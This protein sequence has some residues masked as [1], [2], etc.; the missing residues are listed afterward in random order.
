MNISIKE[1]KNRLSELV[2][3]AEAGETVVVTRDGK[4]VA[5]VVP[6][7]PRKRGIDWEALA[8]WKRENGVE[9]F[10]DHIPEDFDDPLPAD[11]LITTLPAPSSK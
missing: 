3:R 8:L 1:A 10:V 7:Q 6:H 4:P 5:D 9:R 11:F 2:R